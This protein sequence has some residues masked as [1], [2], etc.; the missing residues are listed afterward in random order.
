[1]TLETLA[2]KF[3]SR[4]RADECGDKIIP[5]RRGHLWMDR[6]SLCAMFLDAPVMKPARLADLGGKVWQGSVSRD[7]K[8]KR[9]QDAAV[10][11]IPFENCQLALR[12]AGV[13][14]RRVATPAQ[15]EMLARTAFRK[16]S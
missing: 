13:K 5:G 9:V 7:A 14:R 12:L 1:V 11:D 6:Q 8:G 16:S 3:R 15:R 4:T 2:E 10:R